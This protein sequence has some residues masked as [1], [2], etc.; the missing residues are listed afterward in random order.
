MNACYVVRKEALILTSKLLTESS[1]ELNENAKILNIT[2]S[3]FLD[4]E[5][6]LLTEPYKQTGPGYIEYLTTL[7]YSLLFHWE[8][9]R[10][11]SKHCDKGDNSIQYCDKGDNSPQHCVKKGDNSFQH[12]DK[13]DNCL[14]TTLLLIL[15][16]CHY[17]VRMIGL[18]YLHGVSSDE[19]LGEELVFNCVV[20]PVE[21]NVATKIMSS[22]RVLKKLIQ[23]VTE[24]QHFECQKLVCMS[25]YHM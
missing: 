8:R 13:E 9:E 4:E 7:S 3:K 17:E 16:S 18:V 2:I 6:F 5:R 12:C 22:S 14:E 23:M 19:E 15:D 10:Y 20:R 24:E 1:F 25:V 11:H 21:K